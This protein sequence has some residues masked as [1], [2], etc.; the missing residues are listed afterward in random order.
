MIGFSA[1]CFKNSKRETSQGMVGAE[2][3]S[4][5]R[6]TH[7]RA[8]ELHWDS[9]LCPL[10]NFRANNIAEPHGYFCT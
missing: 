1:G 10:L 3:A 5:C 9:A 7:F 6:K 8:T 2:H 4:V